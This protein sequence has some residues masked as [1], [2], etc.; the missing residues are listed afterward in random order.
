METVHVP[1]TEAWLFR[2]TRARGA[3]RRALEQ[4]AA[5]AIVEGLDLDVTQSK[6]LN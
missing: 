3:V 5:G 2:N 4:L 1:T 6:G